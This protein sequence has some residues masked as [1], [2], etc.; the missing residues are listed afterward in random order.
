M[1]LNFALFCRY[2]LLWWICGIRLKQQWREVCLLM[3][4]ILPQSWEYVH[5]LR[6][7]CVVCFQRHRILLKECDFSVPWWYCCN[8]H[9]YS[10]FCIWES[11]LL[12]WASLIWKFLSLFLSQ[13]LKLLLCLLSSSLLSLY[14]VLQLQFYDLRLVNWIQYFCL[15]KCKVVFILNFVFIIV[16]WN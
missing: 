2:Y 5:L 6:C 13:I 12:L 16:L 7:Q 11:L 8:S 3:W 10:V 9:R 15:I 4:S 14:L 1:T